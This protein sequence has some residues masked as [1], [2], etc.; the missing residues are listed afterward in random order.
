MFITKV[1]IV[2]VEKG[3]KVLDDE[4]KSVM[5]NSQRGLT[6]VANKI[7]RDA[8]QITPKEYGNLRQSGFV[9]AKSGGREIQSGKFV[10]SKTADVGR[11]EA[12]HAEAIGLAKSE[13]STH[14][15][16]AVEIGYSAY[17]F[18]YVHEKHFSNYTTPGTGPKF[19]EIAVRSNIRNAISIFNTYL[20]KKTI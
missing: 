5:R 7:M 18:P 20:K 14:I 3:L 4:I 17:Y 19:L 12:D 15:G 6:H 16:P 13:L 10:D 1:G 2:G 11:L 8:R 9:V